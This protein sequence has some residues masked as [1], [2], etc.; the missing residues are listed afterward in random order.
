MLLCAIII[1]AA[2]NPI[3]FLFNAFSCGSSG[4][5]ANCIIEIS[6]LW[7][8][9]TAVKI[10]I[11]SLTAKSFPVCTDTVVIVTKW[12]VTFPSNEHGNSAPWVEFK[13]NTRFFLNWLWN[14]ANLLLMLLY[15]KTN[16]NKT[17]YLLFF[18]MPATGSHSAGFPPKSD[19]TRWVQMK[20]HE[21]PIPVWPLQPLPFPALTLPH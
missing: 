13:H 3:P 19:E 11:K 1:C 9:I 16:S 21:G 7:Q 5:H 18:L 12:N 10:K 6:F 4:M 2:S 8:W 15:D 17:G 14:S 20:P